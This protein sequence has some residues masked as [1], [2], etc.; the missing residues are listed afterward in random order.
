MG[1]LRMVDK[2]VDAQGVC[3]IDPTRKKPAFN[4]KVVKSEMIDAPERWSELVRIL[5]EVDAAQ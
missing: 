2:K 4:V 3:E 1:T 5:L